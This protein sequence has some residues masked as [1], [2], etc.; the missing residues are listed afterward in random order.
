GYEPPEDEGRKTSPRGRGVRADTLGGAGVSARDRHRLV[1]RWPR[2]DADPARDRTPQPPG[3]GGAR[4]SARQRGA[5]PS[6]R[7]RRM[8]RPPRHGRSL[9]ALH[10]ARADPRSHLPG[11]VEL[12][13]AHRGPYAFVRQL[14]RRRTSA[15]T[16]TASQGPGVSAASPL[17]S[18]CL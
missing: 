8:A 17:A 9:V 15:T 13:A 4:W 14:L 5:R 10:G 18:A 3:R 11:P 6:T 12:V 2:T 16:N 7:G 1:R